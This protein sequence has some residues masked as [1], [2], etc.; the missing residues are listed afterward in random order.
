MGQQAKEVWID[1][2]GN[3]PGWG[4]RLPFVSKIR[5]E[6]SATLHSSELIVE[7]GRYGTAPTEW[8][9]IKVRDPVTTAA[10]FFGR[11]DDIRPIYSAS[12]GALWRIHAR[13][14]MHTLT[15]NLVSH[16]L[17]HAWWGAVLP[18]WRIGCVDGQF[19]GATPECGTNRGWIVRDLALA[20]KQGFVDFQ[21]GSG[22]YG[23]GD[24]ITPNYL[25]CPGMTIFEAILELAEGHPHQWDRPDLGV[26]YDFRQEYSRQPPIFN[27]FKKGS[28]LW[29]QSKVFMWQP[30]DASSGWIHVLSFDAEKEGRSIYSRALAYGH[31]EMFAHG[32]A[33][34]PGWGWRHWGG[35]AD[36]YYSDIRLAGMDN[37]WNPPTSY[38]VQREAFCH[39]ESIQD[40]EEL[41]KMCESRLRSKDYYKGSVAATIAVAGIP[42]NNEAIPRPPLPG[43]RIWVNIPG[44]TYQSYIVDKWVYEEPPGISYFTIGRRPQSDVSSQIISE[45]RARHQDDAAVNACWTS[46]WWATETGKKFHYFTHNL[47]VVPRTV[48]VSIAV[49]SGANTHFPQLSLHDVDVKTVTEAPKLHADP[50]SGQWVGWQVVELTADRIGLFLAD[51]L[52]YSTGKASERDGYEPTSSDGWIQRGNQGAFSISLVP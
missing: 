9:C 32:K 51:W 28:S 2:G 50:V 15:D 27:Y 4:M 29:D 25:D 33:Y 30:P 16:R 45:R 24:I 48:N 7:C 39:D 34:I 26:G 19:P 21:A 31:G 20:V 5:M 38:R 35:V 22:Y 8:S 41:W 18:N 43:D 52:G 14:Y 12:R 11:I 40:S 42:L 10:M 46:H 47:G 36:P 13:D 3:N 44:I 1:S 49:H 37:I 23:S 17:Y 6:S